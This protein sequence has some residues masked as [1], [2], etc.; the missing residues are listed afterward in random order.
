MKTKLFLFTICL[1]ILSM[2]ATAKI[3]DGKAMTGNSLTEFGKYTIVNS[4]A[5]MVHK[6]QV[7]KTYELTYANTS[8]SIR[9]GVLCEDKLKCKTFKKSGINF[10]RNC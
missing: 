7:L 2:G 8:N 10:S 1:A 9:I 6:N 4:D 5:P 3:K